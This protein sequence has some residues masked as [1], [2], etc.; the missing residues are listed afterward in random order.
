[1]KKAVSELVVKTGKAIIL[2]ITT[3]IVNYL[4]SEEFSNRVKKFIQE[5]VNKIVKLV[6]SEKISDTPK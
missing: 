4:S 5:M 3:Q 6:M 2:M 1:M